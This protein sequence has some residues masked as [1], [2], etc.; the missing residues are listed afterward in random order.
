M[1][2][3]SIINLMIIL[4]LVSGC[5][6]KEEARQLVQAMQTTNKESAKVFSQYMQS[7][8]ETEL[9]KQQSIEQVLVF[10]EQERS[11]PVAA[12]NNC[13]K[14]VSQHQVEL[15]LAYNKQVSVIIE[16]YFSGKL[17]GVEEIDG[18]LE[19][20]KNKLAE[21][22]LSIKDKRN[23]IRSGESTQDIK[24][25]L[26]REK[27][28]FLTAFMFYSIQKDKAVE[29]VSLKFDELTKTQLAKL[30]KKYEN[31]LLT[32]NQASEEKCLPTERQQAQLSAQKN[33]QIKAALQE[34]G[35]ADNAEFL[36]QLD[37]Q[38]VGFML[39]N[40]RAASSLETY[41]DYNSLGSDSGVMELFKSLPGNIFMGAIN[42]SSATNIDDVKSQA[43][44]LGKDLQGQLS[45]ELVDFKSSLKD[46]ASETT[47]T[48]SSNITSV[49][50]NKLNKLVNQQLEKL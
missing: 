14:A 32:L 43:Q 3:S 38:V 11:V 31:Q 36:S 42:P 15:S 18:S 28:T 23:R 46:I 8:Q 19:R 10:L 45:K 44:A 48:A 5:A 7:A 40:E 30:T 33:I 12:S 21:L 41:I 6:G 16:N 47:G 1:N 37:K 35:L 39:A 24:D 34:I 26:S 2:I 17:K 9:K 20:L 49:I 4:I 50:T 13:F 27:T 22:E 29:E 25:D